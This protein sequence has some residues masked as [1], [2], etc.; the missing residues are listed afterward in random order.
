MI[1]NEPRNTSTVS[2]LYLAATTSGARNLNSN[3]VSVGV[4][5]FSPFVN[6]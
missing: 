6:T 4:F 2:V 1:R 3:F 5:S